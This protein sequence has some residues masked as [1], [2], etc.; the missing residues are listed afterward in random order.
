[1]G[2]RPGRAG[3]SCGRIGSLLSLPPLLLL[4]LLLAPRSY[5][6]DIIAEG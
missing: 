5:I 3:P 1:M 2:T 6:T 4:L